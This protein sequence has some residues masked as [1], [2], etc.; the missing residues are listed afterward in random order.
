[1]YAKSCSVKSGGSWEANSRINK[2]LSLAEK[3]TNLLKNWREFQRLRVIHNFSTFQSSEKTINSKK[4][5]LMKEKLKLRKTVFLTITKYLKK[6][7]HA[8]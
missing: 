2:R 5:Y 7:K 6:V 1:M 3:R 8:F 4:Q